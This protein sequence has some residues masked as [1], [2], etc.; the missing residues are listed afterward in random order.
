MRSTFSLLLGAG[1]A[2]ALAGCGRSAKLAAQ[3][4]T[5]PT[6]LIAQIHFAGGAQIAAT[7]NFTA[8]TNLF[9]SPEAQALKEQT[10]AKLARAPYEFLHERMAG[11][12]S[13]GVKQLRPLMDDLLRAEWDFAARDATNGSPEY[14]LAVRLDNARAELWQTN[15]ADLLKSWTRLPTEKIQAAGQSGW[16][17]KKDV[18]P[19]LVRF[20]R[21]GDWVVLGCGQN[22]LPLNDAMVRRILA[23]QPPM[24]AATDDWLSL[25][26]DCRRLAHWLPA[27]RRPGWTNLPEAQLQLFAKDGNLRLNG[28]LIYPRPLPLQ[29]APWRF[30]TNL[31]HAPFV[32]FTAARGF[33][34]WLEKRDWLTNFG[35]WRPDQMFTWAL[36]RIPFQTYAAAPA[37]DATNALHALGKKLPALLNPHLQHNMLGTIQTAT[38]GMEL[39][40]RGL[41]FIAPFM[42]VKPG[43]G[44]DFLLAGVFPDNSAPHPAPPALFK[45]LGRTNLVYY[46]WEITAERLPEILNLSQLALMLAG[47]EQLNAQSAAGKWLHRAAPKLGNTV[48][49]I[50]QTAPNELT[51]TRKAPGGLTAVE[52]IALAHWLAATNFPC[53]DWHLPP[54]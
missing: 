13:D 27:R 22:Q 4:T 9:C 24:D 18:P 2:L 50:T 20:V 47:H 31:I 36:P 19:D 25:Q 26:V 49:E 41:P 32:S 48:T 21:V 1:L 29:M 5:A 28:K 3:K 51:L 52:F 45:E 42:R 17:L 37:T 33:A 14:A 7:T 15:L 46:H 35:G 39:D 54:R 34:P 11:G 44:G 23:R 16:Q 53:G 12:A 8:F 43:P 30:P 40:W 38:N 10:F 6:D